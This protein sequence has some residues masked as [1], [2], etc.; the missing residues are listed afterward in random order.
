MN[1]FLHILPLAS[2]LAMTALV[3]PAVSASASAATSYSSPLVQVS[4]MGM[5]QAFSGRTIAEAQSGVQTADAGAEAERG[6]VVLNFDHDAYARQQALSTLRMNLPTSAGPLAL[7]LTRF[8]VFAPDAVLVEAS[9]QGERTISRPDAQY[10]VGHVLGEPQS[11]VFLALSPL[12]SSGFVQAAQGTYSLSTIAPDVQSP[13]AG[14]TTVVN[15]RELAKARDQWLAEQPGRRSLI[16]APW[17]CG[18]AIV[19]PGRELPLS[20][21]PVSA[22][23][24]RGPGGACRVIRVAIDCDN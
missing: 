15:V 18:G 20:Q 23:E 1:R 2:T 8:E 21:G 13:L 12:G 6:V 9:A 5:A 16:P 22:R 4:S 7:E 14:R 3:T 19:P 24:D 10:W 17:T 11:R